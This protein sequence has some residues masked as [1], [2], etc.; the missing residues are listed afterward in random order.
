MGDGGNYC[1]SEH[2]GDV[3][4]YDHRQELRQQDIRR[5]RQLVCVFFWVVSS[6]Q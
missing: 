1:T 6:G 3:R 5:C 2:T 4:Q